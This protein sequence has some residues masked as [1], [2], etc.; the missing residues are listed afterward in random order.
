VFTVRILR[1]T[2]RLL[3]AFLT[4]ASP[5]LAQDTTG[6][7]AITG[8]IVGSD[9]APASGVAVC[10]IETS[11]CAVSGDDGRFRIPDVRAGAYRL[12]VT[13]ANLG[14]IQSD[15]VTVR[16]GLDGRVEV[17]LPALEGLTQAV[18]VTAPAFVA[19]EEIKNSAF[20]IQ[21][22]EI[23]TN[24]AALQDVSRFVQTLPGVVPGT[25]DFRNDIIVRGG[26]PLE[27]LF[28]VDNIEIP[29]INTFANFAS[30][31]GTV[32]IL[33]ANLIQDV[34]FLTGGYP[35]PYINRVSSVLQIAQREGNRADVGGRATF[36]FAG[37]GGI[38]EGP[39]P[40]RRGSWIVSARRS[41]L[42]VFS[43]DVG[44]GG[45]P[46]LY[47][48]NAKAVYDLTPKDRLWV[49]NVTGFDNIRLG[50][51][52]DAEDFADEINT[53]DIR[54]EGQRS[55]TGVNWQRLLGQRSVG[56]LGVTYS[57]AR[58]DQQVKDLAANG[59]VPPGVPAEEVIAA[60]PVVF[61]EDSGERETTIKYDLTT[62]LWSRV[63]VQA[64]GS[65]KFFDIDYDTASPFGNDSPYVQEPGF[66]PFE[67]TRRFSSSQAGLYVQATQD[68]TARLNFTYGA[69]VDVYDYLSSTKVSPRAGI[70]Y[71]F[72]DRW[73][74]RSS[75][76]RYYQQPFFLFLAAFDQNR[77]LVP[78]EADHYVTGVSYT[79]AG[80][81]RASA[82]VYRKQYDN[83]PVAADIPQLSLANIG[84]TFATRD[85][86][87]PLLSAGKG[88]V[89]G[90]EL[91]AERR[92]GGSWYGQASVAISRAR[93]A[94]LDQV[95]RPGSFDYPV[96]V[97]L[98]GTRVFNERWQASARAVYLSGRPYTP[99]DVATSEAQRR[100]VYDL[101]LVNGLRGTDYFR[102]D[103]R[104]DRAFTIGGQRVTFFAGAQNLTN[105]KNFATVGWNRTYNRAEI[106][107]QN[108]IFPLVGF[109]WPF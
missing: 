8:S 6:V 34:T 94:G 36:G 23:L 10:V 74:W 77:A 99:F 55:A 83:Y 84:D 71:A 93:H 25:N 9:G 20:L 60:S 95:L 80:R 54:Y 32:S 66:A 61:R 59:I 79:S 102:L 58:V 38:A 105:R 29:N 82:E 5:S 96:V 15:P 65:L 39:L 11:Q 75:Y 109:D 103:A 92:P 30:A 40:G 89:T 41:I 53:F 49:V 101:T 86:L 43:D 68:L 33:D 88:E 24:A 56:L 63:K 12:E 44:F 3:A 37:A 28:V 26:S 51:S 106:N 69:R 67:L 78:F 107:E 42:D 48:I 100:G 16:A 76:G 35:A 46:T 90:V 50:R 1:L 57:S 64:G 13:P 70:S 87:F 2:S 18:T 91:L 7:G 31:G 22:Q 4:S 85:I 108:G 98:T 52:D 62:T 45:V 17:T 81:M 72:N 14:P 21:Q 73:S 47:T 27:N 104:I 19:P 97:N